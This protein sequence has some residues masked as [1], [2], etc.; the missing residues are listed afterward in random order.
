M[1]HCVATQR[2]APVQVIVLAADLLLFGPS[3]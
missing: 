3:R 1:P 2:T